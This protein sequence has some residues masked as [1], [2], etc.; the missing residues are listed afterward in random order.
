[1]ARKSSIRRLPPP[2]R[3][4]LDRLLADGRYTLDQVTAHLQTLGAAVS[5]SA[6]GRYS[7]EFEEVARHLRESREIAAGFA[8][9]LG[10]LP[11]GDTG[12]MLVE[13]VRS[14]VF[15]VAMKSAGSTDEV[16]PIDLAR[17]AKAIKDLAAGS[18]ISVEMEIK[19][20]ERAKREALEAAAQAAESAAKQAGLDDEQYAL[21]RARILGVETTA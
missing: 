3:K 17:L 4:E 10:D 15:R 14:V 7:Q 9:E 12:H 6:V 20:R 16:E 2:L 8:R 19:I 13:L 18:K 1:M 5:R 21:I 11:E